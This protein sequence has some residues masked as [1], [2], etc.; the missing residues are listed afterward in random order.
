MSSNKPDS[1]SRPSL[2]KRLL[3]GF[4]R[5]VVIPISMALVVIFFVIQAFKIPSGSMEDTLLVGDFLLG[6]KFVY[7]TPLPFTE[8]RLPAIHDPEPGDI[9]IFRFPGDPEYPDYDPHRYTH[10]ANLLMFGNLY[11]DKN[12]SQGEPHLVHYPLGPKDFIKRCVAKSGQVLEVQ[13]G[14]LYTNGKPH[15][16]PGYGKYLAPFREPTPRDFF[17]PIQ[18]PSPGDT[19]HLDSLPIV[20]LWFARSLM[21][22]ENPNS[23]VELDVQLLDPQGNPVPNY[24]FPEFRAPI[25]NHKGLLANMLIGQMPLESREHLRLGDTAVGRLPFAFFHELARTGFIAQPNPNPKGWIRTVG[26]D[27][28]DASQMEDLE[29][30]VAVLNAKLDSA[31]TDSVSTQGHFHLKYTV[32]MDG[33]PVHDYILQQKAYFMMGDN[34]DNSQDSRFWGF[35]SQRN[36]KAKAFIIYFSFDNADNSFSFTNPVSWLRIPFQTRWLRF[37]KLIQ[38]IGRPWE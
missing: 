3:R 10:I 32:L 15:K 22:Q 2:L 12:P 29:A 28:F 8:K 20:R 36:I 31:A 27:S 14:V 19:F 4:T 38:D 1:G 37:G 21:I 34:R 24:I 35:V 5:E 33:E 13:D 26:Y 7:G 25:F 6:L 16:L 23:R 11:W 17:G 9:V 18:I 30:N